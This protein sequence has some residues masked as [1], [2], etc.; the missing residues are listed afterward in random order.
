MYNDDP[1]RIRHMLDAT[2][3]AMSFAS[4]HTRSDLDSD[5]MLVMALMKE[6]EV[7]G[8][9]ASHVSQE[10]RSNHPEI[11]WQDAID[12]RNRLV[13]VYFSIDVAVVW[14][15]VVEDLPPLQAAL[16]KLVAELG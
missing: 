11:P 5:R 16:E 15:T 10:Y 8:E 1:T 7:I 3:E 14:D 12:M 4:G 6:I 13:H 9:A 2:R